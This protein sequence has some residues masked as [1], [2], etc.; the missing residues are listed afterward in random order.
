MAKKKIFSQILVI[1][2]GI[3]IG[4]ENNILNIS[5]PKGSLSKKIPPSLSIQIKKDTKQVELNGNNTI[6]NTYLSH[7]KNMFK[8]CLEGFSKKMKIVYAH[9]PISLTIK[10]NVVE[11]KNFLGERNPRYAKIVG[12]TK[13]EVKGQE[14]LLFG[15][16]KE[17]V[18]QTTANIFQ[19][20][21]ITK[22]DTRVFQDGIYPIE[23]EN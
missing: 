4:L 21:K 7:I 14:V 13:V 19:A 15:P 6:V 5:G 17:D 22:Y 9:F 18:N 16:S 12:Q 1:P 23:S 3:S 10:D 11:I 2:D 8:G 20:V